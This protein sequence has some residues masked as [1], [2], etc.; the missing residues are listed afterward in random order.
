MRGSLPVA[1]TKAELAVKGK[2]AGLVVG[3][4]RDE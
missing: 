1:E 2:Q 4:G 3:R